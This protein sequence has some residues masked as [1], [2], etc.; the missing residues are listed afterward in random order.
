MILRKWLS[1]GLYEN[2]W[3][4][5]IWLLY[6]NLIFGNNL[7]VKKTDR[8]ILRDDS[9]GWINRSVDWFILN[10]SCERQ[11]APLTRY[12]TESTLPVLERVA[13]RL[14]PGHIINHLSDHNFKTYTVIWIFSIGI[15]SDSKP[16]I[17]DLSS[18]NLFKYANSSKSNSYL[19]LNCS[20]PRF[21]SR[22]SNLLSWN[23]L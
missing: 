18:T 8:I 12:L 21:H 17:F 6:C 2:G 14:N 15:D 3:Y 10:I 11:L 20:L 13:Y 22:R 16:S 23:R 9:A 7:G 1:G 4:I 5:W 19:I